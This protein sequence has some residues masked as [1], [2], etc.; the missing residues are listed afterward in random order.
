MS[1]WFGL[2]GGVIEPRLQLLAVVS[3]GLLLIIIIQLVRKE[4][5]KEGYSIWWLVVSVV[6]LIFSLRAN[7]LQRVA[8]IFGV[9]Y[10]PAVLFLII[11]GGL[12]LLS[13]HYSL[14]FCRYDKRIRTLAQEH[15]MLKQEV[16][17]RLNKQ[18]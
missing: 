6:M 15:A 3:S 16:K 5:L 9:S 10:A 2:F 12:L 13:L 4:R 1:T 18:P 14:L 7:L 17:K 11:I 8:E